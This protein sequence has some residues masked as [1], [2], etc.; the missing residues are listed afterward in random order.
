M[1]WRLATLCVG[2]VRRARLS[3][4]PSMCT[5]GLTAHSE[6]IS[7]AAHYIVPSSVYTSNIRVAT[8]PLG[9]CCCSVFGHV[10]RSCPKMF[11]SSSAGLRRASLGCGVALCHNLV[12]TTTL[13]R[14]QNR[15]LRLAVRLLGNY[16]DVEQYLRIYSRASR[17]QVSAGYVRLR[18]SGTARS[19]N[20]FNL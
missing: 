2:F 12:K 5:G 9:T 11:C 18:W 10:G 20:R 3:H 14:Y 15:V 6:S 13:A 19:N 4:S 8:C 1:L 17:I 16:Q 7:V